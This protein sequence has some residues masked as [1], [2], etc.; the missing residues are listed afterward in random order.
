MAADADA[1][2]RRRR[3]RRG[4]ADRAPRRSPPRPS[5]TPRRWRSSTTRCWRRAPPTCAPIARRA[6]ELAAGVEVEP[7][8]GAII[9]AED[10]GPGEVA[11]WS[12]PHRRHR[13]GGRR[14]HGP[15][16]HRGALAGASRSSR[17]PA[18]ALLQIPDGTALG[19]DADRGL[20]MRDPDAAARARLEQRLG[21][22]RRRGRAAIARSAASRRSP[23]TAAHCGCWRTP[24]RAPR[25]T[26]RSRPAPRAS[27]CCAARWPSSRR[28]PG[29]RRRSTAQALAPLLSRSRTASR[30]CARST[31]AATRRRPSWPRPGVGGLLGRARHPPRAGRPTA[32]SSRSCARSCASRATA[33]CAS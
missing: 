5:R 10:L 9:L 8:L 3:S 23:P 1:G 25:W 12:G 30:P 4:R 18:A 21:A 28:A 33:C 27:A 14:R 22:G 19:V 17:A 2:R 29:R 15:R 20:V 11:A 13:A 24:A 7:P 26:P 16:G 31:S 32:A 6:G